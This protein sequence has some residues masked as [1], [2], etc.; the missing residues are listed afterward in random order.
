MLVQVAEMVAKP[1]EDGGGMNGS[2]LVSAA[3]LEPSSL[4]EAPVGKIERIS[5]QSWRF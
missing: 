4:I 2:L 3:V 1:S 5:V